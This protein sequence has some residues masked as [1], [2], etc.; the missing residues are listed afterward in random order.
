MIDEKEIEEWLERIEAEEAEAEAEGERRQKKRSL[1]S[2]LYEDDRLLVFD[3]APGLATI[4]ERHDDRGSLRAL[5]LQ[6]FG[7]VWTVH[8]IDKDTSGVVLFAKDAEAH[9]ELNEQFRER[10]TEKKYLVIV[11]GM[12]NEEE[13]TVDIP[14]ATDPGRSGRIRPSA[15][16]KE[17][18]TIL[19]RRELFQGF[20]LIEAQPL[21]GRQHQIRVHC[22]A[23]GLPLLVDHLYGAQDAFYLSSIKRKFRDYGREERPLIDRQTLHAASLTV[24]HPSTGKQITFEAEPP[25]DFRA[26]LTQLGKVR[27]MPD[28]SRESD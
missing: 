27:K 11:E 22:K 18:V 15:S 19:R 23:V 1:Y 24:E 26:A 13:M 7:R 14:L 17:A 20:T 25:K 5:A 9:R 8:R 6:E 12:M 4:P 28:S 3:K 21:T 2:V 10:K 16:G